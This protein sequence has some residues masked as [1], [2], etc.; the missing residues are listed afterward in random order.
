MASIIVLVVMAGCAAF[1]FSKGNFVRAFA[2]FIAALCANIVAFGWFDQLSAMLIRNDMLPKWAQAVCFLVLFIIT[3]AGLQTLVMILTRPP[4]DLGATPERV[5]R[6]VLGLL[7]GYI[8]SGTLLTIGDLAPLPTS[9]P[10]QRFDASRPNLQ[11]P[12]KPLLNPDGFLT[13]WFGITSS[14]SLSGSQSFAVLHADFLNQLYLNRILAD[15]RVSTRTEQGTIEV[16]SKAAAW[17]AVNLKDS[18]GS[19]LSAKDRL[20]LIIVRIGF[21]N[22]LMRAGSSFTLGQLQLLCEGKGEKQ[23]LRAGA[24]CVYPIGYIKTPGRV[25]LKGQAET[26][27][28]QQS[29]FQAGTKFIDFAFYIPAD[30]EPAALV[31]KSN[32]IVMV[33]GLVTAEESPKPIPF[34]QASD[35][36]T[37]F[38]KIKLV[39]AKI[40]G[41]ELKSG[42]RLLEGATPVISDQTQWQAMQTQQSIQQA[43]F[44]QDQITC[45]RAEL[46]KTDANQPEG[47]QQGNKLPRMFKVPAGYSMLSLKCNNPA[48]GATLAGD[49]LPVLLDSDGVIHNPCGVI[50]TARI[51]GNMAYEVDYCPAKLTFADNGAVAKPFPENIWITEKAQNVFQFY[52]LYLIKPGTMIVSVRPAE[53]QTG[54]AFDGVEAYMVK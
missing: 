10:Y 47:Q 53:V 19:A 21:T 29:D 40:Y 54:A 13:Q 39:S 32:D 23:P 48:V 52:A 33:H 7:L 49:Q 43:Q 22:K 18:S 5:G 11:N 36:A 41:L 4:I 24:T 38:A 45:V 28:L 14:G 6:I 44:E 16:P 50:T 8:L 27:A 9:Y 2:T 31:F 25:A 42:Q 12:Q 17:P 46:K 20:E 35:T 34:M 26:I 37:G 51:E 30:T 1:Q 3:F 15:K